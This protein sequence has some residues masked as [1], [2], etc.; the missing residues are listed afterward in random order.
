MTTKYGTGGKPAPLLVIAS[1]CAVCTMRG[2]VEL[3]CEV[4]GAGADLSCSEGWEQSLP[5][6][7]A[8]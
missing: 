1:G 3:H 6:Q 5:Q 2:K 7:R 8:V 4:E